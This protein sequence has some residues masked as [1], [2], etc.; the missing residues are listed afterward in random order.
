MFTTVFLSRSFTGEHVCS[1]HAQ[2]RRF[3]VLLRGISFAVGF[4]VGLWDIVYFPLL[5]SRGFS[6]EYS[7]HAFKGQPRFSMALNTQFCLV[8]GMSRRVA[9]ACFIRCWF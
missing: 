2:A 1:N 3:I 5:G 9:C 7:S 6:Y 8:G 4:Q